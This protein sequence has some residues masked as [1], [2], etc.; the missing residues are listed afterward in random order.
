MNR[1]KTKSGVRVMPAY[2][3][4]GAAVGV[5]M[6]RKAKSWGHIDEV[7]LSE[8]VR[9]T[10]GFQMSPC[11]ILAVFD[12]IAEVIREGYDVHLSERCRFFTCVNKAHTELEVVAQTMGSFRKAMADIPFAFVAGGEAVSEKTLRERA[13][14]LARERAER[15]AKQVTPDVQVTCPNCGATFRVGRRIAA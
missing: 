1:V 4:N 8:R 6:A 10:T 13:K 9:R 11:G 5:T 7:E 3:T 14:L 15:A 12:A 2:V